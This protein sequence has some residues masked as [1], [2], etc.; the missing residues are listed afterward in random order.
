MK[1]DYARVSPQ[2]QDLALQLDALVTEGR[3]KYAGK[4]HQVRNAIGQR[5][6]DAQRGDTLIVWKLIALPGL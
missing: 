2:E 5:C 6:L 4:R 3:E 1:I